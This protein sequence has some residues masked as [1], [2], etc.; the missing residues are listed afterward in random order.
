[1]ELIKNYIYSQVASKQLE[2]DAAKA[3]L[4][5]IQEFSEQQNKKADDIAVIGLACRFPGAQNAEEYW[6]VLK[7]GIN[8]ISTFPENR[9]KDTDKLLPE[10][11]DT[12]GDV[13]SRG[14][15]LDEVDKFDAG[16]FRISPKE[17][18]L[19][20]PTQRL[21]LE[22]AWEAIEDA[23]LGGRRIYGTKTGVYVGKD[24]TNGVGYTTL[25]D[26]DDPLKQTGAT[27]SILASRLS[28]I[29]DLKGPG[30]V[31]DTACS[32]SL[33]AM[34]MAVNA[35]KNGEIDIAV[36]GGVSVS[37]LPVRGGMVDSPDEMI[38]AFDK[39]ANGTVWG[40]G[41]G[42][43]ILKPLKK[44]LRDRDNVYAVIKGSA[45]NN[46]GSSNGI[47]APSA[48]AQ[49]EVIQQAWKSAGVE[50]K[51]ISYIEA[52][53]TGTK[54]GDP[55]EIK[56]ITMAFKRFTAEKQFCAIGS[57]KT[58]IGHLVGAAGISS[59]IKAVLSLKNKKIPATLNVKEP[60]PLINFVDSPVYL[61]NSLSEWKTEGFPRRCGVSSFGFSGTNCHV[62]LEEA[63][64]AS[65]APAGE[66]NRHVF[67]LSAKTEESI[68][69][70]IK[71]YIEFLDRNQS[72]D[73][74]NI[75]YTRNAGRNHYSY[76]LAVTAAST[77]E[78][79]RKIKKA[80]E[81][82]LG[83]NG[84]ELDGIYFGKHNIVLNK[85][86]K[87]AGELSEEEKIALSSRV[88]EAITQ[89]IE[90]GKEFGDLIENVC[91]LYVEGADIEW[92]RIYKEGL[93]ST[94]NLPAY[95]FDRKR[96]W[97]ELQKPQASNK[98]SNASDE[99][100]CS[101]LI[102]KCLV[103]TM[104]ECIFTT[105]FSVDKH[106]IL[107]EHLIS[108]HSVIPGTT[109]IE[110]VMQAG[111]EYF[112]SSFLGLR[113]IQFYTP[114][115]FN[116]A[117]VK[118]V[119]TI[120]REQDGKVLFTV[121]S[122]ADGNNSI[123]Q[124]QW[125]LHAT[126][127]LVKDE[128]GTPE[129]YDIKA[130]KEQL[131]ESK[132]INL[133][134]G[135]VMSFGPRWKCARNV[136]V[137]QNEALAYLE[138]LPELAEDVKEYTLHPAI[139]DI[140]TS[141]GYSQVA[142]KGLYL[143]FSYGEINVYRPIPAKCYSRISPML[144]LGK[145]YEI[146]KYNV[147]ILDENGEIAVDIKDFSLKR[148]G[149]IHNRIRTL[150]QKESSFYNTVW[151]TEELTLSNTLPE[152]ILIF[153]DGKQIGETIAQK[154]QNSG[155]K[156]IA[157][158]L[159][160]EFKR[161][162]EN[163]YAIGGTQA[164]Y[165]RLLEQINDTN[166][167]LIIH[168]QS[169]TGETV[170]DTV[171]QL[172]RQHQTSVSSLFYLAKAVLKSKFK[173]GID[174]VLAAEN[175]NE[176]TA[177]ES[178]INPHG[179][180]LF[181]LGKVIGQEY[182]DIKVR[183]IDID[184][185]T[186]SESIMDEL[187]AENSRYVNAYREGKRYAEVLQKVELVNEETKEPEIK[188]SGVYI[189]TGGTGGIGIEICSFLASKNKVNLALINR[190][191]LPE[192]SEW[193][194]IVEKNEDKKLASKLSKIKQ[195]E[196][197]G[198]KVD[199]YSA[200]VSNYSEMSNLVS[201]LRQKYG[202]IN[203]II[204]GAGVAGD[205]F[206][207][208]KDEEV[209]NKVLAPKIYGTWILN[210]V[211]KGDNLDF[212]VMFSSLASL[213]GGNGQGD[214]T[215]ANAFMDAFAA[216]RSKSG[217]RTVTINWPAWKETGMAYDYGVN[218]DTIF[219]ALG[220]QEAVYG[221]DKALNS[222]YNGI[223][224][225][226]LN[227]SN[228]ILAGDQSIIYLS[229]EIKA[230]VQGWKRKSAA[231]ASGEAHKKG[232]SV[233]ISGRE[234][235]EYTE[236]EKQVAQIWAEAFGLQAINIY[237]DFYQLGGDS[238]L[239]IKISNSITQRMN[240]K[241]DIV[242]LLEHSSV[243]D[244]AS[245]LGEQ[246]GEEKAQGAKTEVDELLEDKSYELSSAQKRM[247]FL[248]KYDPS[249]TAY[250][251]QGTLFVDLELNIEKFNSAL[252]T[253]LERHSA[254]R[255]VITENAGDPKQVI[256]NKL[257]LKVE[258][259]DISSEKDREIV[260][261]N[262][263]HEENKYVFDLSKP[264]IRVSVYKLEAKRYCIHVNMHHIIT[265]GWSSKIFF[266][267]LSKV[268]FA[269]SQ[270]KEHGLE[271]LKLRYAD[272]VERQ[273]SWLKSE[274]AQRAEEYWLKE[275]DKPLPVLNLPLDFNRPQM[276]TYNGS[277]IKFSIPA[278]NARRLKEVSR[279][280]NSTPYMLFLSAYFLLL[281]KVTLDN[282][283][284]VGF[285][286]AGR[287]SRELENVIGMFMNTAC[288]RVNFDGINEFKQLV[289]YVKEKCLTAYKNGKYPFDLLVT[290]V[291]PERDLS[292]S[293]IFSTM[294]QF[295]EAIP[296]ENEGVS[297]YELS[298]LCR[299]AGDEI[300]VRLE[301]N[302]DLFK[303]ETAELFARYF[304]N[305]LE[306]VK[307]D[308][309]KN[310][311]DMAL[312]SKEQQKQL[313]ARFSNFGELD[314]GNMP[315][316]QLFEQQVENNPMHIAAVYENES[317]TYGEL[318]KKA[319]QLAHLIRKQGIVNNDP[320][321]I[322]VNRGINTLIGILGILKAGG[323]YV[324]ID[325][326][327][328]DA[329]V[330]YML[331]HSETKVLVTE[332]TLFEKVTKLA[333]GENSLNALIDL[334]GETII[335]VKGISRSFNLNDI[336]SQDT[337]NPENVNAMDDLMYIIYTSGSTGLP[338]GVMVTHSNAV[339][340]T[341]WS[342]SD[343]RLC[344]NDRMMLVTSISFDISVFE[345]FGALLSGATLYIVSA[346]RLK[347][348]QLLEEYIKDNSI[349]IWHS[350][351]TLM[352]QM[353]LTLESGNLPSVR[354]IMI[355]GEAWSIE[356]AKGI[357]ENFPKA[358]IVNMY[359]PTEA[360]IWVSS[361]VIGDELDTITSIPI[362][363][364]IANNSII[365]LDS[366]RKLCSIGIPGDI[367]VSG[368]NIT[369]GYYKDEA[370][371]KEVF[372]KDETTGEIIYKT[373]DTGRYLSNGNVE[374]LGRKD[375]MVK[376]RGYRIEVGEIENI[377]LTSERISQAAVIAMKDGDTSKLVCF[378]VS[379]DEIAAAELRGH[380]KSRL[381]DYMI[382]SQF[383]RVE[384]MPLTPNGKID[385]K[386]LPAL[387]KNISVEVEYESASTPIEEK[388][389]AI[390]QEMLDIKNIGVNHNFFDIGGNS[391]LIIK[392]VVEMQKRGLEVKASDMYL[393]KTIREL[394]AYIESKGTKVEGSKPQS[395]K[396]ESI[397]KA[398]SIAVT[399]VSAATSVAKDISSAN[400]LH[401]YLKGMSITCGHPVIFSASRWVVLNRWLIKSE[402]FKA[403]D[404]D[405]V[406]PY[407]DT[408]ARVLSENECFSL[409][410]EEAENN[411]RYYISNFK[412]RFNQSCTVEKAFTRGEDRY[413]YCLSDVY[414]TKAQ[415]V[416]INI[417][418]F[419]PV[420]MRVW[421][422]GQLVFKGSSKYFCSF[423]HFIIFRLNEGYN[424]ILI[425]RM[426][427]S[428]T[429]AQTEFI[430]ILRPCEHLLDEGMAYTF[431]DRSFLDSIENS[432]S[433]IP[434]TAF[435]QQ[436]EEMGVVVL[437]QCFR[438]GEEESIKV[439]ISDSSGRLLDTTNT[440]T[441]KRFVLNVDTGINGVV[442]VEAESMVNPA[443]RS[444]A[445]VFKG[446]FITVRDRMIKQALQRQDCTS[447]IITSL[448]RLSEIPDVGTGL[449]KGTPEIMNQ[450]LYDKVF[451]KYLK[452]ENYLSSPDTGEKKT[453]FDVYTGSAAVFKNSEIDEAFTPYSV[454]LPEGYTPENRYPLL[455]FFNNGAGL[456]DTMNYVKK[457]RFSEAIIV[458]LVGR[459]NS[460]DFIDEINTT[461]II[462]DTLE[463]L[464]VDRD[465]IYI[466]GY[467]AGGIKCFTTALRQPGLAAAMVNVVGAPEFDIN[468]PELEYLKN[469][470]ST[471]VYNL[472]SIDDWFYPGQMALSTVKELKKLKNY[473]Y[474]DFSHN[475]FNDIHNS[476]VLLKTLTEEKRE[477]YPKKL[478]FTVYEP[479]Y[480]RSY[481]LTVERTEELKQ[482]A[483]I[484]AEIIASNH[485]SINS[486]NVKSFSVLVDTEAMDLDEDIEICVNGL[487]R[488]IALHSYSKVWVTIEES[489]LDVSTAAMSQDNFHTE[490]DYIGFDEKLLGIKQLYLKK[491]VI[492]KPDNY[493]AASESIAN[494]IVYRLC[495]PLKASA[496]AYK[497]AEVFEGETNSAKLAQSNFVYL[498]D[499]RDISS[500]QEEVMALAG[501]TAKVGGL[502]Y[503]NIEFMG[504]YFALIKRPN[505][506]SGEKFALFVVYNSNAVQH[507]LL[508]LLNSFDTN[509]LFYSE[510]V[511][512]NEGSYRCF[513][514][515]DN[516]GADLVRNP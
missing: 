65:K 384:K 443:K 221:F 329:R 301:Y 166:I 487:S 9:R 102:D 462:R 494:E 458:N 475:E 508:N 499:V 57:V 401:E 349:T 38:R 4:K 147:E 228:K 227:Y 370:K 63:P 476:R 445:Y 156:V 322:M 168:M 414:C 125:T 172:E 297:Q 51:T 416:L 82:G 112:K 43:V 347:D 357:R 251:L 440:T 218:H 213:M 83:K 120:L 208:R 503:T 465:R 89:H 514:E 381:P 71:K 448:M 167:S 398:E 157:V 181:G 318:N 411:W 191:K 26:E 6:N 8:C 164:D 372:I 303:R 25:I 320:V 430:I 59:F 232:Y 113:N 49:A 86:Q 367:Y 309:S 37:L 277:F 104:G 39:D 299:E 11:L 302:S 111:K 205:G 214:Y 222:S 30:I 130:L 225:G 19:M 484:E 497:Y 36:V 486:K 464:S 201:Q 358:E 376:V 423:D 296:Q 87:A 262:L 375:G 505:P 179:A 195:I 396:A 298:V 432:Y 106:W 351:P 481:W 279:Q 261:K 348:S 394:A 62:I 488:K 426:M 148:A 108:G 509:P 137:G 55:I 453:L 96:Y 386:A 382:P 337:S 434:D 145:E 240:T 400:A 252:S 162:D 408:G 250:N 286:I 99:E 128:F 124:T 165:D 184:E 121:A 44:A 41:A 237:D 447:E 431:F 380:L 94:L 154:L 345:I 139:L 292:R 300:E 215:A 169:I 244:L 356:L 378:Y 123:G 190:S 435:F 371:T 332:S 331:K 409:S 248:Q 496:R 103:S 159:G 424:T 355:G 344:N 256:L 131:G 260:L 295:F 353:L 211:T 369:K 88:N 3:M 42:A 1:M 276:Q 72:N 454:Y 275:L 341:K 127:E 255:T 200:D 234:N 306:Q 151:K 85:E 209:F 175:A 441:A 278:E 310:I 92:S 183:C 60:N 418:T 40:E 428:E 433:I 18:E 471:T 456:P 7:D 304:L 489:S 326:G 511:V 263:L 122:C 35:M 437:P 149:D 54:L 325:P 452:F 29:L 504:E 422:N 64:E 53:G 50:P 406:M 173:N 233:E 206:I 226:E 290:K 390:W 482:K 76:R 363:K 144:E 506:F 100:P 330:G 407:F 510:A 185:N 379:D 366:D 174:I 161:L 273:I 280:L 477:K 468:S 491:C 155:K 415:D 427:T 467:C 395:A 189:I 269:Y 75:C 47:T 492:V 460:S 31:L 334:A 45:L 160:K 210:D 158:E 271:P 287:D 383:V 247:W 32:S 274:E 193:A 242:E 466:M 80:Y 115:V 393:Y 474:C 171:E 374:F 336:R 350:V 346:D 294:F 188:D 429:T 22:T 282:D 12:S 52:H 442:R 324:P 73:I 339:N 425:E 439:S 70:L 412:E 513:R 502:E 79:K 312:L 217:K 68:H 420:P 392:M 438:S 258:F 283:I 285:P 342:I 196:D 133:I 98:V 316:H 257:D 114:L 315:T 93:Y 281:K 48:E 21:F 34:H 404:L 230:A 216:Y 311:D 212:F 391:F 289:T 142:D 28:Y 20:D 507:E 410:K 245:Y 340:Y 229:D 387:C 97:A 197:T 338:K 264:L 95:Q 153:K 182:P 246:K 66:L 249:I 515:Q 403:Y 480:N 512:F 495:N 141:I 56:G 199:L 81:A 152:G 473:A 419:M 451:D 135:G 178:T 24:T 239:A 354:R 253:V 146:I 23:G 305:I 501:I 220:T 238:I 207:V 459:P 202:K 373:G 16:F 288:I 170:I 389:T 177:R 478:Y 14:G 314:I 463:K 323:T 259:Q 267:E 493:K 140:A 204:H 321:G 163:K 109:Y 272:L 446:D 490:Y 284:I 180:A 436:E 413:I 224:I 359:G 485:I 5:K 203:G 91:K 317:I 364:P 307:E 399:P 117:D 187:K 293:P 236:A 377:M 361:Y 479:A 500:I 368:S 110:M 116:R 13:Y 362:G 84:L 74:G 46:D 335:P 291:N 27:T 136:R 266:D 194:A 107:N 352:S 388:L 143:P 78:L 2:K 470:E 327:Y 90:S 516:R 397:K 101:S 444:Q 385:R 33:A 360:T 343:S 10:N 405:S 186:S 450:Y 150:S 15:Y 134:E 119:H 265:D 472:C 77:D 219:K 118:T 132:E 417:N 402:P 319:N 313:I 17:A 333:E 192:R 176:V 231:K 455:V 241:V 457:G 254:L 461:N 61:N 138:L 69:G 223:I 449:I 483:V 498:I 105:E 328:P 365:I 235:G 129:R 67:T 469:I 270:G 58:N 308:S 126:G 421:I 243:S 268:Y 198:S